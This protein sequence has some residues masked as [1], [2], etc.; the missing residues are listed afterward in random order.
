MAMLETDVYHSGE[1]A[2][3]NRAGERAIALRH[4]AM[5][6]D[7]LVSGARAFIDSRDVAAVG[8][9]RLDGTLWAS[10]WCGAPGVFR[11]DASGER[12]EIVTAHDLTV[13]DDPVRRIV[14]R[15][16]PFAMVVIDFATRRRFRINGTIGRLDDAGLELQV[17][18]AFGNCPK[19]IQRRQRF[20]DVSGATVAPAVIGGALD[21]ARVRFI[22]AVDTAFV[23]SIHPQRGLDVSHRGGEAGFV[24]VDGERTLRIPDYPGNGMFQTLG[25][26]AIDRRAGLALV[27]FERQRMLSLT[28]HAAIQ[29]DA[30]DI[31]H[32]SGGTGRY[33]TLAID[34]WKEFALA[35]TIRWTLIDR[36]PFNPPSRA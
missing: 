7:R 10:L 29:F 3:Q 27:D 26:L 36:S 35:P 11:S 20:D 9:E 1:A 34:E 8:A 17:R 24:R 30:E 25:N 5:L 31:R 32:P 12:V 33:W 22:E 14:R 13:G 23:A 18:E 4:G 6:R 2:V 21:E 16:A 15:D 19:Y 28:G